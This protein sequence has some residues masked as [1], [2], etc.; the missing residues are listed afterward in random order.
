V[1]LLEPKDKWFINTNGTHIPKE[2]IG[3]LQLDESFCLST[4]NKDRDIVECIKSVENNFN[5]HRINNSN[6]FRNMLFP[7]IKDIKNDNKSRL[8]LDILA[9]VSST[10]KFIKRNPDVIFTRADKG[11]TTV[12]L[13]RMDCNNKMEINLSD[14]NTYTL[15][16]RNPINKLIEE[17]KRTLKR[18]L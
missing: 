12:A 10:K 1:H 5:R 13:D 15:V 16:Q 14:N 9:S 18:W 8:D 2:V 7:L 3:L 6:T 11:D 17:L 4:F